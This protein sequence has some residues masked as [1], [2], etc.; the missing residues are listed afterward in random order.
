MLILA[1][2]TSGSLATAA[3]NEDGNPLGIAAGARDKRHAETLFSAIQEVFIK[4]GRAL[5]EV[6]LLGVD[7]GPGSFTGVRIGVSAVNGIALALGKPV[8]GVDALRALYQA[9]AGLPGRVCIL[10]DC[11]NGNGYA[12]QYCQGQVIAPPEPVEAIPYLRKL[13]KGTAL[14]SDAGEGAAP[15]TPSAE[16][17]AQAAYG[18]RDTA[19]MAAKPLYLR[20]SQA[21]RMWKLRQEAKGNGD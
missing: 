1:V 9:Q 10:L 18:L 8:V 17:V 3:L 20:P 12:A 13:P 19:L 7:I 11:G 16:W 2:S 6:D 4:T 21:E 14:I 5:A 15:L